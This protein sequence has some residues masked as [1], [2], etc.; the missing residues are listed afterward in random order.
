MSEEEIYIAQFGHM[1]YALLEHVLLTISPQKFGDGPPVLSQRACII[2]CTW[3][4]IQT[5]LA[6]SSST[7]EG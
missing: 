4:A 7:W 3:E 2:S 1:K 5:S 6:M